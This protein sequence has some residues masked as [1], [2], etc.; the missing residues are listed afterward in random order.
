M[1][2][3]SIQLHQVQGHLHHWM[4]SLDPQTGRCHSNPRYHSMMRFGN[5]NM[6][7][8]MDIAHVVMNV[9]GY[10]NVCQEFLQYP[11]VHHWAR[12]LGSPLLLLGEHT[13]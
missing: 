3:L 12:L 8:D 4:L 7:T 2:P 6:D 1:V 5:L 13:H 11:S 9:H 10:R